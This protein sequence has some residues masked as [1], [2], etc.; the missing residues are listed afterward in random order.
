MLFTNHS[1]DTIRGAFYTYTAK[2]CE[3]SLACPFFSN[4]TAIE[5]IHEQN[6]TTRLIVRLC[7]A[8]NPAALRVCPETSRR[9]A[10]FS[11]HE[12]D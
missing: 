5:E 8:T 12:A 9:I 7:S 11:E 6:C 3:V 1:K 4:E 10:E 2:Q